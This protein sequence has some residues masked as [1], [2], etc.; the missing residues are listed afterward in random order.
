VNEIWNTFNSSEEKST[1]TG[2]DL[3]QS[4]LSAIHQDEEI[5]GPT[6]G[7]DRPDREVVN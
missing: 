3:R 5:C 6:K 4:R 2:P 7:G 1:Q